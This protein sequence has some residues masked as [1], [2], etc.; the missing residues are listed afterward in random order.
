MNNNPPPWFNED[1]SPQSIDDIPTVRTPAYL[2]EPAP[3]NRSRPSQPVDPMY[4]SSPSYQPDPAYR[5]ASSI[6]LRNKIL[7]QKQY[8]LYMTLLAVV[9]V[10]VLFAAALFLRYATSSTNYNADAQQS[11]FANVPATAYSTE[12]V[13]NSDSLNSF[14]GGSPVAGATPYVTSIIPN[15]PDPRVESATVKTRISQLGTPDKF[16]AVSLGGQYLQAYEKGKLV[17]WT[18]VTTGRPSMETPTG[19]FKVLWKQSPFTF[20]ALS[21]DPA[22]EYFSYDSKVQYALNFDPNGYF[23]HDVWWRTHY[24]PGSNF[25]SYDKGR[26]E[27]TPGSHGCVNTPMETVAW[28]YVWA[29]VGTHVFIFYK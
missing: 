11:P 18:Y 4:R 15:Y 24:G 29:P 8:P 14:K 10:I 19:T 3:S 28:L 22:S 9:A 6:P 20:E 23:I 27:N 26:Q 13:G 1:K 16:I 25:G 2:S 17:N 21:T 5:S 7:P 12:P